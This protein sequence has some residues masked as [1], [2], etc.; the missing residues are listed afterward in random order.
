MMVIEG[1]VWVG[2]REKESRWEKEEENRGKG[3]KYKLMCDIFKID[4]LF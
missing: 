4:F 1:R 3:L 2:V